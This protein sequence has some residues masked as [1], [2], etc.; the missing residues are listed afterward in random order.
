MIHPPYTATFLTTHLK[1]NLKDVEG[2]P[3]FLSAYSYF[4]YFVGTV[5]SSVALIISKSA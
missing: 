5:L 4:L 1:M 3:F 2:G